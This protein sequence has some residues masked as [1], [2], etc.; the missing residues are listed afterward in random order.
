MSLY[1]TYQPYKALRSLQNQE[2]PVN[3]GFNFDG[4][5]RFMADRYTIIDKD[6]LEVPFKQQPAQDDFLRMLSYYYIVVVLKAR[7]M[8]FSSSALG[9][10]T[11][12]FLTGRNERCVSMSFDQTA[13]EKQLTRAKHFIKSFEY[14]KSK[15]LGYAFKVPLKYN[16][17]SEMAWEGID[18]DGKTFVNTLR[19]GTAKSA[20]FGRGDDITFLHLTEVAFCDD[21]DALL[22]AVG[23]ATVRGAHTILETTANGFNSFKTFWDQAMLNQRGAACLFYLPEWEYDDVFLAAKRKKLGDRLFEQE[24]PPD[25]ETAFITSG[26]TYFRKDSM[27]HYLNQ[28]KEW[29][30]SGRIFQ[31]I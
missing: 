21:V 4:Y 31:T 1:D 8:G 22:A 12:K 5:S 14:I 9:V 13:G 6:K 10:A 29:E 15:Q 7:K 28:V 26:G 20:S 2:Q 16:S 27:Q 25:P 11:T 18:E 24:Y 30:R 19:I 3:T 17:K 23:E